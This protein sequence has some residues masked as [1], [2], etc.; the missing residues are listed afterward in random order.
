MLHKTEGIVLSTIPY[1]DAYS[2]T[3][4][5]TRHF[6]RTAYLLPRPKS[7][8]AKLSPSL[9]SPL[10]VLRLEVD[11]MPLRDIQRIREAARQF[12]LYAMNSDITKISLAFFISE[13]LVKLLQESER[14]ESLFEFLRESIKVL[15]AA[16]RGVANFHLAFMVSL[17]RFLGIGPNMS[18]A[19]ADCYF[20]LMN[21]EFRR[22]M[23]CTVIS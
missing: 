21:G 18:D 15:E 11:H 9:F 23:P 2:I 14:D 7:R 5:F 4:L 8:K 12:P 13:L 17:C 1:S 3:Q 16:D 10:T 22:L 19:G 20:D 6:G